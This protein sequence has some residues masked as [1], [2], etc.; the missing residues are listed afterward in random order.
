MMAIAA[1]FLSLYWFPAIV[2][3]VMVGE[4][5]SARVPDDLAPLLAAGFFALAAVTSLPLSLWI[6]HAVTGIAVLALGYVLFDRGLIAA[7]DVRLAAAIALWF[8]PSLA[9]TFVVLAA[10]AGG[11][12][13]Y[14]VAV[15]RIAAPQHA[16]G[17]SWARWLTPGSRVPYGVALG[18]TALCVYPHTAIIAG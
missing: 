3:Y 14:V 9:L 12:I 16:G 1:D 11:M 8:G 7:S 5:L 18:F 13:A 2:T 6:F 4:L 15:L 17:P 10:L